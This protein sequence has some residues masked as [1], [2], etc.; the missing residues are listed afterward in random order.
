MAFLDASQLETPAALDPYRN[1]A[2]GLAI[3]ALMPLAAV[4]TMA[5]LV[6][7]LGLGHAIPLY[8]DPMKASVFAALFPM[9][10]VAHW[11]A[12]REGE[13]GHRASAWVLALIGGGLIYPFLSVV[14]DDFLRVWANIAAVML[15][16]ATAIR[17]ARVSRIATILVLPSL[18]WVVLAAIPGYV[19]L[20][21]GWSPGFAVTVAALGESDGE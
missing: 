18:V 16:A 17:L 4:F 6:A 14:L 13:A 7:F 5:G 11:L 12:A 10:G 9:W 8:S 3:S 20:T 1:E 19:L 21:N 2:L 15:I